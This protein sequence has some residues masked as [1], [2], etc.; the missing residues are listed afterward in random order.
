MKSLRAPAATASVLLVLAMATALAGCHKKEDVTGPGPAETAGKQIDQ[1][2]AKAG[3]AL[4][5][6]A[7]K[8]GEGLQKAGRKIQSEAEQAHKD[9][10]K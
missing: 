4:N 1:A 6:A 2:A 3:D 7:E 9:G 10:G 8:T 5:Q